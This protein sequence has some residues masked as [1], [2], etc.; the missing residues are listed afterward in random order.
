MPIQTMEN[1]RCVFQDSLLLL[2]V[3]DLR[4]WI[5]IAHHSYIK[6][7]PYSND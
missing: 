2:L 1:N 6:I 5:R 3:A 4:L 7:L